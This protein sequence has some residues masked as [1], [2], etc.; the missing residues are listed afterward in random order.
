MAEYCDVFSIHPWRLVL[1]TL[2]KNFVFSFL[3]FFSRRNRNGA[4]N[5][6]I[7]VRE[8]VNVT[9][10][11]LTQFFIM[12][13]PK[14]TQTSKAEKMW[15]SKNLVE[16]LLEQWFS[17]FSEPWPILC[18]LKVF[19]AHCSVDHRCRTIALWPSASKKSLLFRVSAVC[20]D[21]KKKRSSP[22]GEQFS[23]WIQKKEK[24]SAHRSSRILFILQ[25]I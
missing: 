23:P 18:F 4:E 13:L 11:C 5:G 21:L 10:C 20:P 14:M 15:V 12:L 6:H 1:S 9:T 16:T 8:T 3:S 25:S 19:K 22:L 24:R 17:T 7:K 2:L